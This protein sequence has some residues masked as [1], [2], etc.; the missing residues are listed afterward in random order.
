MGGAESIVRFD[1][2]RSEIDPEAQEKDIQTQQYFSQ[3]IEAL[4]QSDIGLMPD[5]GAEINHDGHTSMGIE[6]ALQKFGKLAILSDDSLEHISRKRF[7][8]RIVFNS[9]PLLRLGREDSRQQ[10]FFGELQGQWFHESEVQSVDIAVK[11]IPRKEADKHKV[12]HEIGMYQYAKRQGIPT[13][14]VLGAV[15]N[16]NQASD[17]PYGYVMTRFEPDIQTLDSLNW[18]NL[19][20]EEAGQALEHAVDTLVVLHS[21]YLF[22]GDFEFKN[23]AAVEGGQSPKVVDLEFG[24]SMR[25]EVDNIMKLSIHMSNDFSSLARSLDLSI[26]YLYRDDTGRESPMDRYDFMFE[27]V[28]LPYHIKMQKAGVWPTGHMGKAYDNVVCRKHDEALGE[29]GRW[30]HV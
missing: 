28:F 25:D 14:E 5:I 30:R 29:Q 9:K 24:D 3:S 12:L 20:R 13:L 22:H 6:S 16:D 17:T 21:N 18:S 8:D 11:A 23:I 26:G 1:F 19:S 10:V 7:P 15:I 27:H 2:S 4:R